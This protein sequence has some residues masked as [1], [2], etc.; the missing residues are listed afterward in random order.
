MHGRGCKQPRRQLAM[1]LQL[2]RLGHTVWAHTGSHTVSLYPVWRGGTQ[3]NRAWK[4]TCDHSRGESDALG[5][6]QRS[7]G[8]RVLAIVLAEGCSRGDWPQQHGDS[9][10]CPHQ[11]WCQC[12]KWEWCIRRCSAGL[13]KTSRGVIKNAILLFFVCIM[14]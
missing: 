6:R 14:H 9:A 1:S 12:G 7:N 11:Q 3:R 5:K 8:A 13:A 2:F 10:W 4:S